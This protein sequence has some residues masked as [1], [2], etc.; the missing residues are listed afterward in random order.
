M[1]QCEVAATVKAYAVGTAGQSVEAK[2]SVPQGRP[3]VIEI[4]TAFEIPPKEK[5][6]KMGSTPP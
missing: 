1:L 3:L 2:R 5:V 4:P 6:V